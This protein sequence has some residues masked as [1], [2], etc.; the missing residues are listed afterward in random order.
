M[1]IA[2]PLYYPERQQILRPDRQSHALTGWAKHFGWVPRWT[3]QWLICAMTA[4]WSSR[5]TEP[6]KKCIDEHTGQTRVILVTERERGSPELMD[7]LE[8]VRAK[9]MSLGSGNQG[10]AGS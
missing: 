5:K 3:A 4:E 8:L 2:S 6:I 10:H 7:L 9:E 1:R